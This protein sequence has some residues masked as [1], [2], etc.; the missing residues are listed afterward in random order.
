MKFNFFC[1]LLSRNLF[2]SW[3]H[4]QKL[5]HSFA[6]GTLI[7][8]SGVAIG[9]FAFVVVLGIM[10]GFVE[11]IKT[12]LIR[13]TPHVQI[14][15]DTPGQNLPQNFR[16]LQ[17]IQNIDPQQI[18]FL[19]PF[20]LGS[21]IIQSDNQA[22]LITLEGVDPETSQDVLDIKN[23]LVAGFGL[24]D[25]D[26]NEKFPAVI[27]GRDLALQLNLNIDSV[28]TLVSVQ[29]D[30]G[31]APTQMPVIVKG[32]Y[33]TGRAYLD[34]KIVYISLVNANRFF[35][36][37][38]TWKGIQLKLSNPFNVEPLVEKLNL[39]FNKTS[40]HLTVQPWTVKNSALL[41]ALFL[42]HLGMILVMTMIILVGCFSITISLLLSLHRK[43]R[44][45][46]I[47]RGLGLTQKDLSYLYLGQGF[48]IGL[49][50][51][52]I[53]LSLGLL[54]LYIVHHYQIPFLTGLYSRTSLPIKIQ[55]LDITLVSL[56][57]LC[58]ATLAAFWP[59]YK[60]RKLNVVDVL[61]IRQ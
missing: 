46:A 42:E 58:L 22:T 33:D 30:E 51:V 32:I 55:A 2:A 49:C 16:F 61:A 53:G 45:L 57:S 23:F 14:V 12:E 25:L 59:A 6:V 38:D 34:S 13:L 19:S 1:F 39:F 36:S 5:T 10:S 48:A 18:D 7:P 43:T 41:K 20:Q 52:L 28:A 47:L 35:A 4:K 37:P 44:E 40:N 3:V 11:N 27:V 50:G 56:G 15:S 9:V 54:T 17:D 29:F 8:I 31:F 24:I 21:S 60:A 26:M